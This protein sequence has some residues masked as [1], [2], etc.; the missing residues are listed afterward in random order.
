[1][2]KRTGKPSS[3]KSAGNSPENRGEQLSGENLTEILSAISPDALI[4]VSPEGKVLFWNAG[5][6]AIFGYTRSEAEGNLLSALTAPPDGVHQVSQP[7]AEES[8][9]VV[10]AYE[11]VRWRKDGSSIYVDI[12]AK[13]MRDERG[14]TKFIV[15]CKKDVTHVKVR[16]DAKVLETRFGGLLESVPDAIVMVNPIGR[17]LLINTHTEHLFGYNREELLGK[18]VE[19]LLPERYR[20]AHL[21]HRADYF[22]DP[23]PRS[24]G[25]GL[26]LYGLRKDGSEF[27]V[28]ISLSPLETGEGRVAM[29]AIRDITERKNAEQKF[30]GL[31]ESAP[32][33]MIMVNRDGQIVVVNAEAEK[34]F[35]YNRM[36]LLAK[37]I[38]LLVPERFRSQHPDH[39]SKFFSDPRVRPMGAGIELYAQRKDGSEFPVEISLSPLETEEGVFATAAI[40][41]TT[42]RKKAEEKFRALLESAP[43]AMVIVRSDGQIVLVNSQTEKLF[44]YK[45]DELLGQQVEL[46]VPERFRAQHPGHRNRYFAEPRIRGMGAGLELYGLRKDGTEFPV[47][48]S[49]SPIDTE[50]GM[51]V[52]SAIRNISERK[53]QEEL[54]RKTLEEASRLKSEFLANMSHELRTPLNGIIG[55]SQLMYDERLG[56]VS[57]SHKEYL[58]DILTSAQHLLRLINDVLDLAKVEAGKM[59][60][61]PESIEI[62]LVIHETRDILRAM[63]A[64][65]R[66]QIETSIDPNIN[67]AILDPAKLKQVLY[68]FL[69]NAIKFTPEGGRIKVRATPEGSRAI[70]IEVEDTGIGI[71]TE[72][73]AKLFIEF[74][75][76][77]GPAAKQYPGTGLGLALTKKIV[78]A[79]GGTVGVTSVPGKG[80]TFFV[81]LPRDFNAPPSS[82]EIA[83]SARP[84]VPTL[85]IIEDAAKERAWLTQT[86]PGAGY[87][88]ETASNG[89]RA[90]ALCRE[91]RFDAITLDL[92]LP[93][94]SGQDLLSQIRRDTLNRETPVIVVTVVPGNAAAMGYRV[95]EFLVKPVNEAEL[96]A[97]LK[98]TGIAPDTSPKI[99]CIDDDPQALKLADVALRNGGYLP[100]T[101]SDA[102]AALRIAEK[103]QPAAIIL[104]LMMPGMDGFE[105][106]ERLRRRPDS[107]NTPVI[108]WTVKDLTVEDR[109]RLQARVQGVVVKG[110]SGTAQLFAELEK[111]V[112]RPPD[113]PEARR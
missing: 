9:S 102:R 18:S 64:E 36:E 24:M 49:L 45:R 61:Q 73:F 2:K 89:T 50:D 78:E 28:E 85:L 8:A 21:G 95:S 5:A 51:L 1:M 20:Q 22:V 57:Q 58:G 88:V 54:R 47:E 65:K 69:S 4:A 92:I 105:F 29:S 19:I 82:M 112:A 27:P 41:D 83:A 99:L 111:Y 53:V 6:E 39:R 91:R 59:E 110:Q 60:F 93:D 98:R 104:D 84:G 74:Q 67:A 31:L 106:M 71:K 79:Q 33:A 35:G 11:A 97:A 26:E 10:S 17:I 43:D 14:I 72:D 15:L 87:N 100:L 108:V 34:L 38:E 94:I 66:L 55:F 12:T 109:M 52:S 48:F 63:A 44:Q 76:L 77:E 30:R 32:D 75:Q 13:E 81:I 113:A 101:E 107:I 46:L 3:K 62:D 23:K 40:R 90:L 80:S 16:R 103:E 37:P 86:L 7:S 70:R 25:A 56:P 68:N 96:V 42:E